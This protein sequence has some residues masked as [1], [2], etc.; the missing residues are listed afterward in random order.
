MSNAIDIDKICDTIWAWINSRNVV[1]KPHQKIIQDDPN[2]DRPEP[3]YVSYDFLTGFVEVGTRDNQSYDVGEDAVVVSG[4][5][6]FTMSIKAYGENAA[7]VMTNLHSSLELHSV[8]QLFQAANISK[9][10]KGPVQKISVTLE[11]GIEERYQMDVIF[12][13]SSIL[14]EDQGEIR[15]VEI[16]DAKVKDVTGA[17]VQTINETITKP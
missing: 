13:A 6:T 16:T 9:Q 7:Q 4:P 11:T 3:P 1:E 5:R 14:T 17:D 10:T 15:T 12:N 2:R 8:Q